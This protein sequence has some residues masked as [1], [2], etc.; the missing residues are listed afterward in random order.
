M[1]KK[2]ILP[3]AVLAAIV[4]VLGVLLAALRLS[5]AQAEDDTGIALCDFTAE[6]IDGLSYSGS[7]VEVTLVKG[8]EGSWR[9]D[10]DPTLPLE[11]SAVESLVE[12]FAAL[13]AERQLQGEELAQIPERSE[14]PQMEF[15][16]TAGDRTC[17]L[18]VDQANE[19]AEVYYVYDGDGNAYTVARLDLSGICK[20]PRDLYKAQTLTDFSID[21][22]TALETGGMRF[23][24]TDDGW[25]LDGEAEYPLE[26]SAV[27]KMV[28]TL[29]EMQTDWT[30]T[31]PEADSVY[32]LD[33]PDVTAT[34][35]FTD[36]MTLTVRLGD[37]TADDEELCY[38]AS[39]GAPSVVY[40][41]NADYKAA[42]AVTKETLY[43]D[44][45]TEETAD[46]AD[47]A[48]DIVAEHPVGGADDYVDSVP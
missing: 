35:T 27:K 8:S 37:T 15:V 48:G 3:L 7:N 9:L 11:Q 39:S 26:Q 28:N 21:D 25:V 30:V 10:S 6:E 1:N 45:A 24:Q 16:L 36:G 34:L 41:A 29:C 17:T 47:T 31:Q 38:V 23:I 40:E 44:S 4:A 20:D 19:L 14:A 22:V 18:T 43:D 42:F 13:T 2:K 32:G 46:S 5:S 33:T 12:E